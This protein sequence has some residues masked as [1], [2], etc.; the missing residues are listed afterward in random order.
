MTTFPDTLSSGAQQ[1]AAKFSLLDHAGILCSV[2][3]KLITPDHTAE[4]FANIEMLTVEASH[5]SEKS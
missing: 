1:T 3:K 2:E 4:L 5:Y